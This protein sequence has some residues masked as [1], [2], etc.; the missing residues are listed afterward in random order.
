VRQAAE[1]LVEKLREFP[2]VEM[3][4]QHGSGVVQRGRNVELVEH[5]AR[6]VLAR[7]PGRSAEAILL[8]AHYDSALEGTGAGDDGLAAAAIV[9][10]ARALVSG[11]RLERTVILN[12]SGA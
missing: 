9:E 12:L 7:I 5:S 2:R 3:D 11:A 4:L 10:I 6:N 1:Y 8:T